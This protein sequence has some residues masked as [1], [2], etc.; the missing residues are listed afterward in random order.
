MLMQDPG[1]LTSADPVAYTSSRVAADVPLNG[2]AGLSVPRAS[3]CCLPLHC[4]PFPS[5][6]SVVR[7]FKG[8]PCARAQAL[9]LASNR[10]HAVCTAFEHI[11]ATRCARAATLTESAVQGLLF[12]LWVCASSTSSR[13]VLHVHTPPLRGAHKGS[14]PQQAGV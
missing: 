10:F 11:T 7:W 1:K 3:L 14:S 8:C 2:P 4:V 5:M 9:V 6:H 13:A 12:L